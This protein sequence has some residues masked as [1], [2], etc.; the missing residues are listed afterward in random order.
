MLGH[1]SKCCRSQK[2]NKQKVLKIDEED[3]QRDAI[4]S[5][6]SE[7]SD[8]EYTFTVSTQAVNRDRPEIYAKVNGKGFKFIVDTGASM[9]IVNDEVA[10]Q[11]AAKVRQ[12]ST[13]LITFNR[14]KP[15]T[16]CGKFTA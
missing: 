13:K 14:E 12:C 7:S 8:D 11:I 9:N 2:P 1:S 16:A 5:K 6:D 15:L 3:Y 10:S 4:K